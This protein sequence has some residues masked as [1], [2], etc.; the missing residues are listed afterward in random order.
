VSALALVVF[1]AA[2]G[3]GIVRYTEPDPMAGQAPPGSRPLAP[4]LSPGAETPG[5]GSTAGGSGRALSPE[6]LQGMLQAARASLSAG[7]YGEAIAAY[8]A[9]LKREPNNVDAMT[10]LGLIVAIGGHADTALETFD[11]ALAIEP[12]YAPALLYRG[13]VLYESKKNAAG[14]IKAWEQFVAVAPPGEERDRVLRLIEEA[15]KPEAA[16]R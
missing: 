15:R 5:P 4:V 13:R 11:R 9:V 7:R 1:G 14:A 16:S 12:N 10:H 6:M 3:A 2:L 8:Q